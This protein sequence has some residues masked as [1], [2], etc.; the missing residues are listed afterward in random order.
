MID[1]C[2][3][4]RSAPDLYVILSPDSTIIDA[5]DAYLAAT[6]VA[7][8][9]I[10][11]CNLFD[12][13]PDNPDAHGS[14]GSAAL[15]DSIQHVLNTKQALTMPTI[16]YD[17]R[18]P[19]SKGGAFESRYWSTA[20]T[21]ILDDQNNVRYILTR[22]EDITE[23][24]RLRNSDVENSKRLQ[25]LIENIKEYA[26][27][28]LDKDRTITTWNAGA[29][30][31]I[32]YNS[33]EVIGKPISFIYPAEYGAHYEYELNIAKEK[34]AYEAEGWRV[35][36]NGCKFWARIVITPIYIKSATDPKSNLIGYAKVI[37]D[38]SQQKEMET[39]KNGF[40]S[41]INHELRTPLTSIFG[42][43]RLL[44]NWPEHTVQNINYLLEIANANCERLLLLI[45]DI[46]DVEKLASSG[47]T[48]HVQ[49]VDLNA[50]IAHAVSIN[51]VYG[52]QSGIEIVFSPT[53]TDVRVNVDPSRLTQVLT[54]L[55]SNAVKFSEK[56][57]PVELIL[58]QNHHTARIAVKNQGKGIPERFRNKIF[59]KFSQVDISTTRK[60]RGTGLGL[61]ISQEIIKQFGSTIEYTSVPDEETIFYFD[62]PLV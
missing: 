14:K 45:N 13:F 9:D 39:V 22:V 4:I 32:G 47:M 44:M 60:Q 40:I 19:L 53:N 35:R 8:E 28:M 23:I 12:I 59:E 17:I 29:E 11:G 43:I 58:S 26:V 6:M 20:H 5:S 55:I 18:C 49:V 3:T 51:R 10:V 41:V 36:K 50:L 38:L 27:I 46:L 52:E 1:Y 54:N 24:D 21:P 56:N 25:L 48:L 15:R 16:K 37:R 57:S 62:L 42:A 30:T 61:A 2:A 7:R 33:N 31:I 34:G